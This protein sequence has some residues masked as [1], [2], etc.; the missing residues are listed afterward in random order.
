MFSK[1]LE[2]LINYAISDGE[3]DKKEKQLIYKKA[4]EDGVDLDELE[5]YLKYKMYGQTSKDLEPKQK[6]NFAQNVKNKNHSKQKKNNSLNIFSLNILPA[7]ISVFLSLIVF[8]YFDNLIV[9]IFLSFLTFIFSFSIVKFIFDGTKSLIS[10]IKYVLRFEWLGDVLNGLG[11]LFSAAFE[12][13]F[14]ILS[15]IL[16]IGILVAAL[17]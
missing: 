12:S 16:A 3:I 15:L 2:D 14:S 8:F 1:E 7:I 11:N 13:V 17:W 6:K 4:I 5:I 9:S 10:Y